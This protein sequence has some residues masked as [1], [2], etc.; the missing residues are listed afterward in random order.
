MYNVSNYCKSS[1]HKTSR[2]SYCAATYYAATYWAYSA[3]NTTTLKLRSFRQDLI[4]VIEIDYIIQ[5]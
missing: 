3:K 1:F 2:L 5:T 4:D